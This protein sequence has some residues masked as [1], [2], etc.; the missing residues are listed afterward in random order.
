MVVGRRMNGMCRDELNRKV[1][2]WMVRDM[3]A[4]GINMMKCDRDSD[5]PLSEGMAQFH[6]SEFQIL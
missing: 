3:I 4:V 6:H 2:G 1:C 5:S